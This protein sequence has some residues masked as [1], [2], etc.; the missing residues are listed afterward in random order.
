LGLVRGFFL[1]RPP[2]GPLVRCGCAVRP[3][4][5]LCRFGCGAGPAR[6]PVVISRCFHP[7]CHTAKR[8]HFTPAGHLTVWGSLPGEAEDPA[9]ARYLDSARGS[10][11][12]TAPARRS[13]LEARR[14]RRK[15]SEHRGRPYHP[16]APASRAVGHCAV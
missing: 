7:S 11:D 10:R 8:G 5:C 3:V 6:W 15:S 16:F 12:G 4:V 14:D 2:A 9:D 13:Y 1:R